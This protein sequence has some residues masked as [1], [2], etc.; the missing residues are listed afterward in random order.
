MDKYLQQG[1]QHYKR[2]T[3]F[4]HPSKDANNAI[5]KSPLFKEAPTESLVRVKKD[6][7]SS[8]YCHEMERCSLSLS[9]YTAKMQ[10]LLP[11]DL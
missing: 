10:T 6:L 11:R 4:C 8:K 1:K 3:C 2:T 7:Q 9:L 5:Y